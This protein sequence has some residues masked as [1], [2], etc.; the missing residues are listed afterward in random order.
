MSAFLKN[1]LFWCVLAV[2][3]L[4]ICCALDLI[5][6]TKVIPVANEPLRHPIRVK[7]VN[8][9]NLVLENGKIVRLNSM[10]SDISNQLFRSDFQVDVEQGDTNGPGL[11]EIQAGNTNRV[12]IYV[13]RPSR[14]EFIRPLSFTI[15]LVRRTA[16]TNHRAWIA[17]GEYVSTSSQPHPRA[18]P[19]QPF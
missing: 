15:P 7:Q 8:G 14:R 9:T 11:F 5:K 19:N 18:D 2:V 1:V 16:G 12:D 4:A 13:R 17:Y 6:F 3:G 10:F